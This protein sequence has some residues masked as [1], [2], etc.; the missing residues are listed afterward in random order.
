M[1]QSI[2]FI[3]AALRNP[4]QISTIFQTSPWLSEAL[5]RE[6]S[7]E[8]AKLVLELG[9]GAGAVTE[10][11]LARLPPDSKYIGIE[12]NSH[13]VQYLHKKYPDRDFLEGSAELAA[14]VAAK[15]GPID[16]IVSSLPWTIFP[17]DLQEQIIESIHQALRPGGIFATYVCINASLYPAAKNL[18]KILYSKFKQVHKSPIEWR[19]IPPAFVYSCTK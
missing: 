6:V 7:L 1:S 11:L 14:N 18:K 5:L 16:A 10:P 4:F 9:P 12:L 15:H 17:A 2:E 13:L 8:D 3:K 19:N